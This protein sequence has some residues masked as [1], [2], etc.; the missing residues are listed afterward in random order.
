MPNNDIADDLPIFV[1]M[2]SGWTR[3]GAG[4]S[5]ERLGAPFDPVMMEK[6]DLTPFLRLSTRKCFG[7]RKGREDAG[8]VDV[9]I[10]RP[11]RA[12][13]PSGRPSF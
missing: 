11:P 7:C 10:R 13:L 2:P 1:A 6:A 3:N 4:S 5:R 9:A 8:Q 12:I